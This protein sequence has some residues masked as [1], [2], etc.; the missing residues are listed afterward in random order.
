MKRFEPD[1]SGGGACNVP[2]MEECEDGE[3]VRYS[4]V[5]ELI[6]AVGRA[7]DE[8]TANDKPGDDLRLATAMAK[9]TLLIAKVEG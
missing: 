8:W 7:I 1:I 3:W 6:E 9:L 5:D 4:D 2:C